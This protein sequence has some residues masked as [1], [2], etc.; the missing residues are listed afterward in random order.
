VRATERRTEVDIEQFD[1]EHFKNHHRTAYASS[2][3]SYADYEPA[4]HFGSTLAATNEDLSWSDVEPEARRE[5][6]RENPGTW[7]DFKD[8]IR[9]GWNYTRTDT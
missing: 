2:S 5:W 9:D 6:E 8:A 7:G 3:Y 4:Y 1:S